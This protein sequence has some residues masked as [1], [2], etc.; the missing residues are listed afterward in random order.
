MEK[1]NIFRRKIKIIPDE[2]EQIVDFLSQEI[3]DKEEET[4]STKKKKLI[5]KIF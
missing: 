3:E 1:N 5:K 4:T 2:N